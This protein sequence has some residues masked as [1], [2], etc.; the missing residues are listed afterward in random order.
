M[1]K[2]YT[3]LWGN[4]LGRNQLYNNYYSTKKGAVIALYIYISTFLGYN[5]GLLWSYVKYFTG[6]DIWAS[7]GMGNKLGGLSLSFSFMGVF[8]ILNYFFLL[9]GNRYEK[10]IDDF[11]A[12]MDKKGIPRNKENLRR[13][14]VLVGFI[15][16][17][18]L[19]LFIVTEVLQ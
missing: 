8:F 6:F 15:L 13:M 12:V 9:K 4:I 1:I 18:F 3:W 17:T 14:S 2:C 16:I 11:T 19:I 7:I 10:I 5:F